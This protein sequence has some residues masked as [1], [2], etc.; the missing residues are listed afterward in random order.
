[1]CR[2]DHDAHRSVASLSYGARKSVEFA[3]AIVS[4]PRLLLL[5]EPTAGLSPY[6]MD[7][8]SERLSALRSTKPITLLVITHHLEFLAKI[9]DAVTVLDLGRVIASG[10]PGEIRADAKVLAAYVGQ[11]S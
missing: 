7:E 11:A 1:M 2:L 5:D 9:A 3:R 8:L 10:S 4:E 6:E